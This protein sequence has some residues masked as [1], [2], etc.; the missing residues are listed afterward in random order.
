MLKRASAVLQ[1]PGHERWPVSELIG[2]LNEGMRELVLLRPEVHTRTITV[3]LSSGS[4]Q[5]VR[6][7]ALAF[8]RAV[9]T[10]NAPGQRAARKIDPKMLNDMVHNWRGQAPVGEVRGFW[11][12]DRDLRTFYVVPPQDGTALLEVVASVVPDPLESDD[13][14]LQI[15]ETFDTA[16]FYYLMYRAL[17][18]REKGAG[19]RAVTWHRKFYLALLRRDATGFAADLHKN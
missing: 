6:D 1:D 11:H 16:L 9:R 13:D 19:P 7:P 4:T 10:T 5:R 18:R 14:Q 8:V 15:P 2:Y 17:D 12:D 3:Q